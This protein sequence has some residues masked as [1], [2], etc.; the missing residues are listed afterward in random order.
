MDRVQLKNYLERT[1]QQKSSEELETEAN[2]NGLRCLKEG[3]VILTLF[4]EL[5]FFAFQ[6]TISEKKMTEILALIRAFLKIVKKTIEQ[7]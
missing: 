7:S 6:L 2:I 5:K 3:L 1:T 4:G